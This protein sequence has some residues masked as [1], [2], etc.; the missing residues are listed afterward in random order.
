[1]AGEKN[2]TKSVFILML[3]FMQ[4]SSFGCAAEDAGPGVWQCVRRVVSDA[5]KAQWLFE[6]SVTT[7][8]T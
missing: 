4:N 3:A 1:L 5:S 8:P 7:C 2:T 6:I